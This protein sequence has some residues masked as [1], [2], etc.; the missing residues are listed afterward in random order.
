MK[1]ATLSPPRYSDAQPHVSRTRRWRLP[2][3]VAASVLVLAGIG[4]AYHVIATERDR[5]TYPPPG[6][7]VDVGGHRL[8]VYAQG[9]T[10]SAPTVILEGGAGL[11]SVTWAWVQPRVAQVTRVVAYDRAGVG[12]SEAGPQPRDARQIATELRAALHSAG[13]AGPYVMVGHSFGGLYVRMFTDLNPDEVVG[14]V[15]VDP[16]HPEQTQRSAREAEGVA[17]TVRLMTAFDAISHVGALRL[18]NP[19]A[20]FMPGLPSEQ[21]AELRAYAA[22]GFAATAAAEMRVAEARTFP[23]V[24]QTRDLGARPL[25]VL[26][27]GQTVAADPLFFDLHAE[28]AAL[29]SNGSHRVVDGASHA[30]MVFDARYAEATSTAIEEVVRLARP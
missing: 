17:T 6:Q 21:N 13:I 27:A 23:Q 12:W 2:L 10:S 16:T 22:T 24:R 1:H 30:G 20:M 8:H 14:L 4:A 26:S 29:S 25:I 7:L 19:A 3:R 9:A 28:L 15:L 5:R 18:A 11:G